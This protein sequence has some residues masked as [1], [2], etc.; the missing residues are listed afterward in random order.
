MQ[1]RPSLSPSGRGRPATRTLLNTRPRPR[2]RVSSQRRPPKQRPAPPNRGLRNRP[3]WRSACSGFQPPP[4]G[5]PHRM[6]GPSL[7]T[8]R[9]H[10]SY[11]RTSPRSHAAARGPAPRRLVTCAQIRGARGAGRRAG[12]SWAA[13]HTA[14]GE[15]GGREVAARRALHPDVPRALRWIPP[16]Q[17]AQ[18]LRA[19]AAPA[20]VARTSPARRGE[21]RGVE[22]ARKL[23]EWCLLAA[24]G[25]AGAGSTCW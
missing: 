18:D 12:P 25:A 15:G 3:W 9:E 2:L 24:A 20:Q 6:R 11:A 10:E 23:G 13:P 7:P 1:A 16:A 22:M 21:E 14:A 8:P 19:A 4:P 5:P 17:P